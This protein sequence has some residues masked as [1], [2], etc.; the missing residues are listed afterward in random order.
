MELNIFTEMLNNEIINYL[1]PIDLYNIMQTCKQYRKIITENHF[2]K[3]VISEINK[4]LYNI[5]GNDMQTFKNSMNNDF[6]ITGSFIIQCILGEIWDDSDLNIFKCSNIN[7]KELVLNRDV[8]SD[9]IKRFDENYNSIFTTSY[10]SDNDSSD[11]NSNDRLNNIKPNVIQFLENNHDFLKKS[12]A[13][14]K[15][16]NI[17]KCGS[18]MGGC[19]FDICKNIFWFDG[20]DNIYIHNIIEILSRQTKFKFT[21]NEKSSLIR[22]KKY[23]QRGFT[24]DKTCN[25]L[26]L[27]LINKRNLYIIKKYK[28]NNITLKTH[29]KCVIKDNFICAIKNRQYYK[30]YEI[31]SGD[32]GLLNNMVQKIWEGCG[33]TDCCLKRKRIQLEFCNCNCGVCLLSLYKHNIMHLHLYQPCKW[34]YENYS[35]DGVC[36]LNNNE[37]YYD[38]YHVRHIDTNILFVLDGSF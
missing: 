20:K 19:D 30:I 22:Y 35:D 15:I 14:I 17:D 10:F 9:C 24:F 18:K 13:N 31:V 1:T 23:Q 28:N 34:Y 29:E 8:D 5:F 21:I 16:T 38:Y 3:R 11:D 6:V 12:S 37:N 25:E 2:N 27:N 7:R 36:P 4:R 26:S 33:L 32:M